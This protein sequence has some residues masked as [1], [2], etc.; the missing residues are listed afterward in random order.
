MKKW[1]MILSVLLAAAMLAGDVSA[2]AAGIHVPES[3]DTEALSTVSGN[4]EMSGVSDND[5]EDGNTEDNGGEEEDFT[6]SGGDFYDVSGNE[7]TVSGNSVS[8][9]DLEPEEGM[10]PEEVREALRELT[11]RKQVMALVYLTDSYQ[12]R[13]DPDSL[14]QTVAGVLSGQT[15]L[16]RDVAV[17]EGIVWY[18]TELE[19]DGNLY[20]GYIER[21]YLAYSDEELIEWEKE[22]LF[23]YLKNTYIEEWAR[24]SY[25]QNMVTYAAQGNSSGYRDIDQFPKSYWSALIALKKK[26]PNWTF[27]KMDVTN[28]RFND[29][30]NAQYSNNRSW[31]YGT[32]PD[33][34][35]GGHTGQGNWYYATKEA[36]TH[37]LDPRN[38]L[39]EQEIFQFE[40]LTYN[41]TYHTESALAS[42]LSST[43]MKGA[44]PGDAEKR[45]YARAFMQIGGT[46]G[47][48]PFHLAS[49]VVQE[50][51]TGGTSALISGTYK[52]YEGYY[53][54]FNVGATGKTDTDVIV[55]GLKHAKSQGWNTRYK[56]LYGGAGTIGNNYIKIGQNTLYLQKFQIVKACSYAPYT[57]QYQQNIQAP[58]SEGTRIYK[59]YSSAGS[60]NNGFVF[61]IPVYSDMPVIVKSITLSEK[62]HTLTITQKEVDGKIEEQH[63][64][65]EL[66]ATVIDTDDKVR[67]DYPVAWSSSPKGVVTVDKKGKVT[68]VMGGKAT[69]TAKA[70][71]KSA[72][73]VVT[74]KAPLYSMEIVPPAGEIYAGGSMKLAVKYIPLYTS[75][76][77]ERTVWT[78]SDEN[79]AT[80]NRGLV[81]GVGRGTATITAT[82]TGEDGTKHT[83][84]C[85]ITVKPCT[86]HF[87]KDDG[88]LWKSVEMKYGDTLEGVFPDENELTGHENDVFSG[89]YTKPEGEGR[90]CLEDTVIYKEMDIYP[91]FISTDQDFFVKSVGDYTYT[92]SAIKPV[93]EVYDGDVPLIKDKDYTVSY[94]NNKAAAGVDSKKK[95]TITVKGKGNYSGVQ[96]IYFNILQKD[97]SELDIEAEDLLYAH[98]G[99]TIKPSPV[100]TRNG[101]KLKKNTDFTVEYPANG[102]GAYIS[103][104]VFPIDIS[105]YKNYT[106][107][108][109]IFL[110][111]TGN[112]LLS[113]ASVNKIKNQEYNQGE[114]IRPVLTVKYKGK[115]LTEGEDYTVRYENNKEIGTAAAIITATDT[116][117]YSGSKRVTFKIVGVSM[118]KVKVTGITSKVY[119]GAPITVYNENGE[120]SGYFPDFDITYKHGGNIRPL[121]LGEDYLIAYQNNENKGTASI[122][123]IG[124]NGFTGT[125]KK[126][127]KITAYDL[128]NNPDGYI[129]LETD[130]LG[131]QEY[132]RAGVKPKVNLYFTGVG[133][134]EELLQEGTDYTLSYKNNKKVNDGTD[135]DKI[136]VVTIKGKGRFKGTWKAAAR[137]TIGPKDI[138][139]DKDHGITVK[140]SDFVYKEGKTDYPPKVVLKDQGKT[141]KQNKDYRIVSWEAVNSGETGIIDYEAVLEAMEKPDGTREYTGTRTVS[142]RVYICSLSKASIQKIPTQIYND[143]LANSEQGICPEEIT[144]TYK[145]KNDKEAELFNRLSYEKYDVRN[146]KVIGAADGSGIILKKG[147]TVLLKENRDYVFRSDS[148]QNNKKKGK[149]KVVIYGTDLFAGSKTGRYTIASRPLIRR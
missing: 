85:Q 104:G 7:S 42:I 105:G 27:A 15:V 10:L 32:A 50:Q 25:E 106:G 35:K 59:T 120:N 96:K 141:L 33:S 134:Q 72:K 40:L 92:G 3:N 24:G 67:P 11:S 26:Y 140:T 102:K 63:D 52:G 44:I 125:L 20:K 53:N 123:F 58:S 81:T 99:K 110:T 30:V 8:S 76:P 122:L 144:V 71:D 117:G 139:E 93:V 9:N 145:I 43:F 109:R 4:D 113:K 64:S 78:S 28:L 70:G 128:A 108:R 148:W 124:I 75:D 48:S 107:T 46:Y 119:C 45:S 69:V 136:P 98:T 131:E 100:V 130:D 94:S 14:S 143:K 118:K 55:N 146:K 31:I 39:S 34:Y 36:I 56:S 2:L 147:D 49:R 47:V 132:G 135:A 111:I 17:T 60:L 115:K 16:I 74:V 51:G 138:G 21:E 61:R 86:V 90:R 5:A 19:V 133:G 66:K 114:E 18:L 73:C 77:I 29:V 68:T 12:V 22:Y 103:A 149:A 80:V 1:K 116:G 37:Y 23:P 127:F 89:W 97:I 38:H 6:V 126:T 57:H 95:P 101:K 13:K 82:V 91:F 84:E 83:A 129:R 79:V 87:Y 41:S 65:F 62:E 137:F 142:Y 112:G 88:T 54:Y 121:K